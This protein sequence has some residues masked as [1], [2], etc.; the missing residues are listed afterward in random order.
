MRIDEE[1]GWVCGLKGV[2]EPEEGVSV[3]KRKA[4][5]V[6]VQGSWVEE[7]EKEGRK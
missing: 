1:G 4:R 2:W 7:K 5:S 6:Q 3:S